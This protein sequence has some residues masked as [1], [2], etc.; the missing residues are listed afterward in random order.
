M[1]CS[2]C[3]QDAPAF[4]SSETR[5]YVCLR[6]GTEHGGSR[7]AIAEL[8]MKAQHDAPAA[9]GQFDSA[10]W[11]ERL[12]RA[13]RI[14]SIGS[15]RQETHHRVDPA[16]IVPINRPE[17][18]ASA[19]RMTSTR[20]R[21]AKLVLGIGGMAFVAGAS[22]MCVGLATQAAELKDNGLYIV[23]A[24]QG[25]LLGGLLLAAGEPDVV[26]DKPMASAVPAH[27]AQHVRAHAMRD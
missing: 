12:G 24:T 16:T 11:D 21:Y 9:R 23:V 20:M 19:N 2:Q 25:I 14:L 15:N 6:C 1:W 8:A 4:A 17:A 22:M 3:R 10:A 26:D 13:E 27:H 7:P 18:K 5:G